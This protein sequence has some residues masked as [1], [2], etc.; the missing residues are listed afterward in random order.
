[1]TR[2]FLMIAFTPL[3]AWDEGCAALEPAA[4]DRAHWGAIECRLG[5]WRH[6]QAAYAFTQRPRDLASGC[7]DLACD[8][9]EARLQDPG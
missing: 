7:S 5:P 3:L 8:A 2:V 9:I 6:V 4:R 1:M